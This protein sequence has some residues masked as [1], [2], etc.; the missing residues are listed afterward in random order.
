M[1]TWCPTWCPPSPETGEGRSRP[2]PPAPLPKRARGE[3]A[4]TCGAFPERRGEERR[5]KH[6]TGAKNSSWRSSLGTSILRGN[7]RVANLSVNYSP[8][9]GVLQGRGSWRG[10]RRAMTRW[11]KRGAQITDR[12]MESRKMGDRIS[13]LDQHVVDQENAAAALKRLISRE[14]RAFAWSTRFKKD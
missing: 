14:L 11:K 8:K 4:L 5:G 10:A 3:S 2:S 7:R 9:S 12:E 1:R 13:I 6:S